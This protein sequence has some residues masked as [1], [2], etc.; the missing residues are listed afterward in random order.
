[1]LSINRIHNL[2]MFII[3]DLSSDT[4]SRCRD[5][6]FRIF[7]GC[8][9]TTANSPSRNIFEEHICPAALIVECNWSE[10]D[11]CY[12]TSHATIFQLYMWRHMDVQVD[13]KISRPSESQRQRIK[14]GIQTCLT[15]TRD[16]HLLQ[17]PYRIGAS[18]ACV[19]RHTTPLPVL[20]NFPQGQMLKDDG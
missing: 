11:I 4:G 12:L 15:L 8:I 10:W 3:C 13:W 1:M 14:M 16:Q 19:K 17:P 18:I 6:M 2:G 20:S 5:I 9:K 7:P